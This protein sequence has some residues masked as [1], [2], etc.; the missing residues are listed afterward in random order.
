MINILPPKQKHIL[1]F[2]LVK[3]GSIIS[4]AD[5]VWTGLT[6][7]GERLTVC[8]VCNVVTIPKWQRQGYGTQLIQRITAYILN[9]KV[10]LGLLFC[11]S[12]LL[13]FYSA[14]GWE[15][16][17]HAITRIGT[18]TQY[19]PYPA[20]RM[21]LLVSAK[22]RLYQGTLATQPAYVDAIW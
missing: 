22:S 21:I 3:Q 11:Q 14:C 6:H 8:G 17:P 7:C 2:S 19:E 18:P 1:S 15:A 20:M 5:V 13:P 16:E 9:Q 10:D 4:R 12:M